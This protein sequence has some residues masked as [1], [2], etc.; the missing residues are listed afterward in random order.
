MRHNLRVA[1][2]VHGGVHKSFALRRAN[3]CLRHHAR[4]LYGLAAREFVTRCEGDR[5]GRTGDE[6]ANG[7]DN[8]ARPSDHELLH[9]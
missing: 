3:K 1:D 7:N 9:G 4:R 5:A 2:R 6:D 8:C